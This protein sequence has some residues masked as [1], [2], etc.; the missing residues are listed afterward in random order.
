MI[1]T[2]TERLVKTKDGWGEYV[3]RAISVENIPL[4]IKVVLFEIES[5]GVKL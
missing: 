2:T 1:V 5:I 4:N 3:Y